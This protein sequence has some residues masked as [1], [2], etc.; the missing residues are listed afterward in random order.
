[1][2]NAA[3]IISGSK[4]PKVIEPLVRQLRYWTAE[5]IIAPVGKKH[6]GSGTHREYT[7]DEV[8]KAAIV[9][10]LVRHG[11]SV[12]K[13][14]TEYFEGIGDSPDWDCAVTGDDD[15]FFVHAKELGED[16][17]FYGWIG[18][19]SKKDLLWIIEKRS[20]KEKG[21]NLAE[22]L[23]NQSWDNYTSCLVINLTKLFSNLK[24]ND[25]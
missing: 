11:F 23:L 25:E 20:E 4:N 3:T 17:G 1:V 14:G 21:K 2:R 12:V 24:L 19:R 13:I 7:A 18:T 10:E 9:A 16:G 15:V 8:R 6:A 22:R 5:G